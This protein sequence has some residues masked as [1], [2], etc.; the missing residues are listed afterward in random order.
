MTQL[1]FLC[2]SL[3]LIS[4]LAK[5]KVKPAIAVGLKCAITATFV[6]KTIRLSSTSHYMNVLSVMRALLQLTPLLPNS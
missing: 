4:V 6:D 3:R 2:T 5:P 1:D